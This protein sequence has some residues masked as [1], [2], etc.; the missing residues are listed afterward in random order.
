M[1]C[2]ETRRYYASNFSMTHHKAYPSKLLIWKK[3]TCIMGQLHTCKSTLVNMYCVQLNAHHNEAH[4]ITGH[5][6]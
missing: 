1:T 3:Y 5:R 4:V 2:T 6:P